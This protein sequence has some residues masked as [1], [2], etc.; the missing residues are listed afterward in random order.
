MVDYLQA[1]KA[2]ETPALQAY[3]AKR[4]AAG[5]DQTPFEA[6]TAALPEYTHTPTIPTLDPMTN[7]DIGSTGQ[8]VASGDLSGILAQ[9][10]GVGG[11]IGTIGGIAA[12]AYGIYEALG[13]GEGEGLFGLDILGGNGNGSVSAP[14]SNYLGPVPLSG[15][16]LAEPPAQWVLKEWHVNY[17][18]PSFKLQYYLVQ[19][20]SGRRYIYLWNSRTGQW[21]YWPWRKPSLA[22]IG[23]NMPTH[24]MLTRLRRNLKKHTADAKSLLKLTSPNTLKPPKRRRR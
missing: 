22:V 13:G 17:T 9:L 8:M 7:L 21:K 11:A 20:P 2:S 16:G 10:G 3:R 23:K 14:G 15:P 5:Y 1:L 19:I 6:K 12:T 4:A 24:K 18:N